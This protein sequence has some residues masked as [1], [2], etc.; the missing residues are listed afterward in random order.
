M[1]NMPV[2]TI[3]VGNRGTSPVCSHVTMTGNMRIAPAIAN[4][5]AKIA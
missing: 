1:M 2:A 5:A 4:R 3:A